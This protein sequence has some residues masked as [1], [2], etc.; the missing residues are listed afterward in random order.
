[1]TNMIFHFVNNIFKL[2]LILLNKAYV[3]VE[4]FLKIIYISKFINL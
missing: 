4:A 2:G 1:M 3:N